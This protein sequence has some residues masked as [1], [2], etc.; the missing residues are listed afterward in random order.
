MNTIVR[1]VWLCDEPDVRR[2]SLNLDRQNICDGSY[3]CKHRIISLVESDW[4]LSHWKFGLHIY[5][6]LMHVIY[7]RTW[8]SPEDEYVKGNSRTSL[9]VNQVCI[10]ILR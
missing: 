6:I 1:V 10:D 3:L 2:D 8:D 5:D 4:K 7:E 9:Y